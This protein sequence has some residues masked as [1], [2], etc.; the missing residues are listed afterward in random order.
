DFE[1]PD[2]SSLLH[3]DHA[4]LLDVLRRFVWSLF[5][6]PAEDSSAYKTSSLQHISQSL[7]KFVPWM[8]SNGYNRF[9]ELDADALDQ[10]KDD[11]PAILVSDSESDDTE[12]GWS[13]AYTVL[14]LP[15]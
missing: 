12:I 15:S 10:Y 2:G 4:N 11:I 7:R 5:V 13:A 3:H 9:D 6:A 8:I 1:L 14:L